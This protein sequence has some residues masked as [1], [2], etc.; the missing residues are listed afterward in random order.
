MSYALLDDLNDRFGEREI[1]QL[2]DRDGDGEPDEDVISDALA[3]ADALID[4]YLEKRYTLPLDPVPATMLRVACVLA[5]YFLYKDAPS[6]KV[7]TDYEDAIA[8]LKDVAKGIVQLGVTQ[9]EPQPGTNIR[10]GQ[11]TSLIDWPTYE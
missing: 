6:D 10:S 2:A 7:R 8:W 4:S 9:D 11:A 3:D 5:R 1:V